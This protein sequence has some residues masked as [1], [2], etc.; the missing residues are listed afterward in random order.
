VKE[1]WGEEKSENEV[2]S[3]SRKIRLIYGLRLPAVDKQ[4]FL[5]SEWPADCL[6]ICVLCEKRYVQFPR[7]TNV[8]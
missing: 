3:V 7:K 2:D 1:E 4:K 5:F 6:Y 8:K